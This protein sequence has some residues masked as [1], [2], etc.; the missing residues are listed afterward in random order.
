MS[1]KIVKKGDVMRKKLTYC[2][3]GA[4]NGGLAMA[5]YLA[6]IGYKVNLFNRTLEKI[7]PLQKEPTIHLTGEVT[8]PG[9]LNKVTSHI[10]EAIKDADVIMVT[11]PAIG[12][13]SIA[14]EMATYVQDG[15]TLILNPGRTGGA[16]EVYEILS[17]Q[18]K[19][20]DIVVAEAQTL[21]YAARM[22]SPNSVHIFQ[23]KKEVTLAA[24]PAIKTKY[25]LSL[26]NDAYPQFIEAKDV[27]E[28]S[29]NNYGAIFHPAPTLLNSG[30]IERGIPFQYYIDGITPSIGKF[31]EKMDMERMKIGRTLQV[32]TL[33]ALDW[34][35][36]TYEAHGISLYEGVQNTSAYKGLQAPSGLQIRYIYEDVPCS[37]VPMESIAHVLGFRTPAISSIIDI[38]QIMTGRDFRF[39]GRTADK[40]GLAG[41]TIADMHNLA[42]NGS[43]IGSELEEVM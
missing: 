1:N 2:I 13:R 27:L 9:I 20:K 24:I 30:H 7:I 41:L 37:L 29:I 16:L 14:M 40:L 6:K 3:I 8:G 15:Q 39:E 34:L 35:E 5:G 4:G 11:I 42:R 43:V 26:I 25:V 33:S 18:G 10:G 12:H 28:T 17:K 38:A 32:Q 23:T 36:E 19:S 22:T 21:I 31:L